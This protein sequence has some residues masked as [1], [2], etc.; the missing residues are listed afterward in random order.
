MVPDE[1]DRRNTP[2]RETARLRSQRRGT[3]GHH[4]TFDPDRMERSTPADLGK[5]SRGV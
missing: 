1:T 3:I 2:R 5:W 4:S